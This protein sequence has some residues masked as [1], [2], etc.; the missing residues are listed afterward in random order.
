MC[1]AFE[2]HVEILW[3]IHNRAVPLGE[4][5]SF[6]HEHVCQN[7]RTFVK[8]IFNDVSSGYNAMYVNINCQTF[9]YFHDWF[10]EGT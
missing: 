1:F 10:P 9:W 4:T 2:E 8:K 3:L 7:H 6:Q 5:K